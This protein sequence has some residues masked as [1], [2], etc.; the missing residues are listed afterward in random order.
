MIFLHLHY[1]SELLRF[2]NHQFVGDHPRVCGTQGL[3][4]GPRGLGKGCTHVP[5]SRLDFNSC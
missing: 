3:G 4:R 1:G 5:S 2:L